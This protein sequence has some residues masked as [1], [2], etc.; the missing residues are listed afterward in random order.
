[1]S[2]SPE[3]SWVNVFQLPRSGAVVFVT[4]AGCVVIKS[5]TIARPPVIEWIL[6]DCSSVDFVFG[7]IDGHFTARPSCGLGQCDG[8]CQQ[9]HPKKRRFHLN[10]RYIIIIIKFYNISICN[11]TAIYSYLFVA[12]RLC[13]FTT[14]KVATASADRWRKANWF[15]YEPIAWGKERSFHCRFLQLEPNT[16]V[17]FSFLVFLFL[18]VSFSRSFKKPA[19]FRVVFAYSAKKINL[20]M[21][22]KCGFNLRTKLLDFYFFFLL[23]VQRESSIKW[24]T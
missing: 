24:V 22:W 7:A 4:R 2:L 10:G 15:L 19:A 5:A 1:M 8:Q 14:G 16:Y 6:I 12:M 13:C 11:M 9:N 17:G 23:L 18:Q 3:R 20:G 21:N